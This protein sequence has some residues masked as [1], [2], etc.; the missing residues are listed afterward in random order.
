MSSCKRSQT[1]E[2]G[3]LRE[4][5]NNKYF[6]QTA[7]NRSDEYKKTAGINLCPVIKYF[8]IKKKNNSTPYVL[9]K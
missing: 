8:K 1:I 6:I 3:C 7:K 5:K 2:G 9:V 4:L